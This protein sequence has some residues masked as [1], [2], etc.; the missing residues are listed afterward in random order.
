MFHRVYRKECNFYLEIEW[1]RLIEKKRRKKKRE[2]VTKSSA[3]RQISNIC[4]E[5]KFIVIRARFSY[6]LVTFV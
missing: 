2:N 5:I 3:C 1:I 4:K 6:K